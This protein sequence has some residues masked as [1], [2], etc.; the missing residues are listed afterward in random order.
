MTAD[1]LARRIAAAPSRQ[2]MKRPRPKA[3]FLEHAAH[4]Y[5][6]AFR[7]GRGVHSGRFDATHGQLI[8]A[9]G[10]A[11]DAKVLHSMQRYFE[12]L[13]EIGLLRVRGV[14]DGAGRW[15]RLDVELL[16]PPGDEPEPVSAPAE[17]TGG[18]AE[19]PRPLLAA[20]PYSYR[21]RR[22]RAPEKRLLRDVC[23]DARAGRLPR[24]LAPRLQR[25]SNLRSPE[26]GVEDFVLSPSRAALRGRAHEGRPADAQRL[27][28]SG[29][30][31]GASRGGCAAG[32]C[33]GWPRSTADH[34]PPGAVSLDA[35]LS[36]LIRAAA[37]DL[38]ALPGAAAAALEGGANPAVVV[39]AAWRTLYGHGG[40][41]L[42]GE[43]RRQ[44]DIALTRLD[45][46]ADLGHGRRGA[47]VQLAVARILADARPEPGEQPLV[48]LGGL[49][50]WL[51]SEA[52]RWRRSALQRAGKRDDYKPRQSN[53][54]RRRGP[55]PWPSD[56][57]DDW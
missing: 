13:A 41:S 57:T 14:R 23:G 42:N 2:G 4:V 43:R 47:G 34:T 39:V 5:A 44:L 28:R 37:F 8:K 46:Y 21:L 10:Y 45:R 11:D 27:T 7:W 54:A 51:D 53:G 22:L 19:P 48:R 17:G 56:V 55:L 40:A 3:D 49:A 20:L 15:Q 1:E 33:A 9:V 12:L 6:T 31:Q 50:A 24:R 32:G 52:R 35:V 29:A 30:A 18:P 26:R 25:I 38:G 36:S 16:T